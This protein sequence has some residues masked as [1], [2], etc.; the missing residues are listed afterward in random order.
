MQRSVT[1]D[2]TACE[3][4]RTAKSPSAKPGNSWFMFRMFSESRLVD[5]MVLTIVFCD[6]F[7]SPVVEDMNR[8]LFRVFKLSQERLG[9][10]GER[11][12]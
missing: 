10:A 5:G 6:K 2:W 12:Q 11:G 4:W 7:F 1:K 9:G 8:A 3:P